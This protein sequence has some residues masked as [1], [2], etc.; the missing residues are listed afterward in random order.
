MVPVSL[1]GTKNREVRESLETGTVPVQRES[2]QMDSGVS[3]GWVFVWVLDHQG[4]KAP[5]GGTEVEC[6]TGEAL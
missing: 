2:E 3:S 5:R 4:T 6:R 1:L